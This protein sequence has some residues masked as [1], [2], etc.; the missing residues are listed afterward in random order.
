MQRGK[1]DD[2]DDDDGAVIYLKSETNLN[3]Y[4]FRSFVRSVAYLLT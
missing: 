1:N 2:D 4:L 3:I